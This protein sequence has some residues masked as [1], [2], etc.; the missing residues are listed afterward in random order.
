MLIYCRSFKGQ[1]L[2]EG[3]VQ[4]RETPISQKRRVIHMKF[5]NFVIVSFQITVNNNHYD[6]RDKVF[7]SG[8]SKFCGRQTLTRDMVCLKFFK[9]CLPQNLLSP[10]LNTLSYLICVTLLAFSAITF[11][12]SNIVSESLWLN[13]FSSK[14]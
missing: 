12:F 5:R 10:L 8:L 7:M 6:I 13:S 4:N 9:G 1:R 3:D 11:H 2:L 14:L